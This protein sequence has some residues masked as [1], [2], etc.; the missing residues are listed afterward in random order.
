MILLF[1]AALANIVGLVTLLSV[2]SLVR[3]ELVNWPACWRS[4]RGQGATLLLLAGSAFAIAGQVGLV[5]AL[6]EPSPEAVQAHN[7]ARVQLLLQEPLEF[8]QVKIIGA[9][10]LDAIEDR[11]ELRL[12]LETAA[13][14]SVVGEVPQLRAAT[15]EGSPEGVVEYRIPWK[16]VVEGA[17][18][19]AD[20]AL[21]ASLGYLNDLR[22]LG[23]LEVSIVVRGQEPVPAP[24]LVEVTVNGNPALGIFRGSPASDNPRRDGEAWLFTYR[25]E[26]PLSAWL[27]KWQQESGRPNS[28]A[29]L[30][31][32]Y[33]TAAAAV[34]LVLGTEL[35]AGTEKKLAAARLPQP[36]DRDLFGLRPLW[37]TGLALLLVFLGSREGIRSPNDMKL[38][39]TQYLVLGTIFPGLVLTLV[40][41]ARSERLSPVVTGYVQPLLAVGGVLIAVPFLVRHAGYA[42]LTGCLIH[43]SLFYALKRSALCSPKPAPPAGEPHSSGEPDQASRP[44]GDGLL[45]YFAGA[46]VTYACWVIAS[47]FLWWEPYE[48]WL[49]SSL[50]TFITLV[51]AL[52]L[53]F[54]T[55]YG[56]FPWPHIPRWSSPFPRSLAT[57]VA[58]LILALLSFRTDHLFFQEPERTYSSY[59]HWSVFVGPAE[60]VRQGGW[61]LWDVPSHYG[62][63]NTLVVAALPVAS[64]W[65]SMYLVNAFLIFCSAAL[66]FFLLRMLGNRLTHVGLALAATIV[67][68]FLLPGLPNDPAVL[69]GPYVFPS[70]AA[71]R[72]FWAYALVA[73]AVWD[74]LTPSAARPRRGLYWV[75][76]LAWLAGSYWSFESAIYCA[77]AWLP[78]YTCMV[79]RDVGFPRPVGLFP[80]LVRAIPWLLLPILLLSLTLGALFA[81]Y[82]SYLGHGPDWFAFYEYALAYKGGMNFTPVDA[83]GAVWFLFA[84]FCIVSTA[85]AY[86]LRELD[87]SKL[88]V[89]SC[90]WGFLWA[91]ASYF[92][93][94]GDDN[95]C[96]AASP[97]LCTALAVVLLTIVHH[98]ISDAWA[99]LARAGLVPLLA[100]L[101]TIGFG[102]FTKLPWGNPATMFVSIDRLRPQLDEPAQ[103]ALRQAGVRADDP[104]VYAEHGG[105]LLPVWPLVR[106]GGA[107]VLVTS[108]RAWLPWLPWHVNEHL[109]EERRATYTAR[110]VA[111]ARAGGY[112]LRGAEASDDYLAWLFEVLGRTHVQ[113]ALT[114]VERVEVLRFEPKPRVGKE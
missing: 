75:G 106:E 114:Q 61:L 30:V 55:L 41:L 50:Y 7:R 27:L 86:A 111:R 81:Y 19:D 73:I 83:A 105:A 64:A 62:F 3:R 36:A 70:Q 12:H 35:V 28:A 25:D 108:P 24:D 9:D 107:P 102:A 93:V 1:L 100:V 23:R 101:L 84:A 10:P 18:G 11:G 92:A 65:Q 34:M 21:L 82:R 38:L 37:V 91:A 79:L 80:A 95:T 57:A 45:S 69:I 76:C 54:S 44:Q 89:L 112:L 32:A 63:L 14:Q 85:G 77:A 39:W 56:G 88:S 66:L 20:R 8:F 26:T 31:L 48:T 4:R 99:E 94:R 113:T 71:Y 15:P 68:V 87:L 58:L 67:A 110:F 59:L 40:M 16:A 51:L 2:L 104:L 103:E 78:A 46:F 6:R 22:R 42:V 33:L 74:F 17:A 97:I 5:T 98:R 96:T 47:R 53:A 60:L 43:W 29:G 52:L 109:P 90:V 72:Y 49:F 13:G